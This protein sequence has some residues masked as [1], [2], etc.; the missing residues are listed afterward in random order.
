M[1]TDRTTRT[2]ML[3]QGSHCLATSQIGR[4]AVLMM[5]S[6]AFV[7]LLATVDAKTAHAHLSFESDGC[8]QGYVWRIAFPDDHV[9]VTPETRDQAAYDNSQA[10]ERLAINHLPYGPDTCVQGYVWRG[11]FPDDHVCVT[12]ETRDQAAYDNSQADAR[13]EPGGGPYGPDTCVQGYVWRGARDSD[14]VCVTPETR[15]QTAYDNSQAAARRANNNMIYIP[16]LL[17][18]E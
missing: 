18:W 12:T 13:R 15:D 3:G 5:F 8:I 2:M 7:I 9:C 4:M 10:A 16:L 6:I 17:S 11:A 1:K 14:H